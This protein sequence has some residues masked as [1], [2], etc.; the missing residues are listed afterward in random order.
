VANETPVTP[1]PTPVPD[2]IPITDPTASQAI[3][4]DLNPEYDPAKDTRAPFL[5]TNLNPSGPT[6][7]AAPEPSVVQKAKKIV[8]EGIPRYSSRT[9]ENPKYGREQF[10]SPEEALTPAEQKQ[11][12]VLTGAL[13]SAGGLTSPGTIGTVAATAGLGETPALIQKVAEGLFALQMGKGVYD[14]YPELKA[15]IEKGKAATTPEQRADAFADTQRILTHMGVDSF[16]ALEAATHAGKGAGEVASKVGTHL[17]DLAQTAVAS[18]KE[19]GKAALEAKAPEGSLEA[20]FAK[21]GGKKVGSVP[22]QLYHGTP[23]GDLRG[24]EQGLHVGTQRAATQAL[25]ARI[26]IRADGQPWDGTQEYGKTLL[27]GKKTLAKL[28]PTGNNVTGYNVDVPEEDHYPTIG[29]AVYSDKTPVATDAKPNVMPVKITGPMRNT[30][31]RPLTDVGANRIGAKIKGQSEAAGAYYKN[32]GEDEGSISAVLPGPGHVDPEA[33]ASVGGKFVGKTP[34]PP[35]PAVAYH[36]DLQKI[37]DK[38]GT[39]TDPTKIADG[40]SFIAPDGKFIPLGST[41]HDMA[42]DW[43]QGS[44]GPTR[45]APDNRVAFINDSK[46]VR[47][48]PTTDKGGTTLHISVPREGISPEQIDALKQ[49]VAKGLG[50]GNVMMETADNPRDIKTAPYKELATDTD[51]EPML[52]QIGAHPDQQD[53]LSKELQS[54]LKEKYTVE[55]T[56]ADGTTHMEPIEAFSSKNAIAVA[57]KKFPGTRAYSWRIE[58]MGEREPS[59][60]YSVPTGKLA[61]MPASAGRPEIH[62]IRHELGHAMVGQNEGLVTGG[63]L[64]SSHPDLGKDA[65]AAVRWPGRENILF[66]PAGQVRPDK[67]APIVKTLMGGIAADEVFN[68]LPRS[69][70]H[71][72]FLGTGGDGSRAYQILQAAG[73]SHEDAMEYMHKAIDAGKEY[74]QH[75]AVSGIINENAGFRE[76]GLSRQFHAS[77]DR[78]TSMHQ[79]AQRRIANATGQ[80]QPDNRAVSG[81]GLTGR[82]GNVARGEGGSAQATG[83]SPAEAKKGI[84]SKEKIKTPE[85]DQLSAHEEGGG[86]TFTPAGE[87]LAGKDLYSVGAYPERTVQVDKLTPEVLAK[88]KADN[89]DV[90][91]KGDH[92]VG[93]WKDPD[94]GKAVLDVS[95]T[96]ADRAEAVAAGKDA[97]QK[98]IYHLGGEGEIQTGGTGEG[99]APKLSAKE[100]KAADKAT[101]A[102]AQQAAVFKPSTGGTPEAPAAGAAPAAS[103]DIPTVSTR[104]PTKK[105]KGEVVEDHTQRDMTSD[106]DAAKAAP[107]Y[108]QKMVNRTNTTPGFTPPEGDALA[109]A[110]AYIRHAADNIKFV[111]SKMLP[112]AIKRDEKWYP[113]GAH[114][115]VQ[116]VAAQH[117]FTPHQIAGV[118]AVESPMTDWDQNTSLAERTANIWKNQQATKFT[119]EM[120]DAADNI[121]SLPANSSFKPLIK[122]VQGKTLAE[123][124][125][126]EQQAIW[127][128]LYDE[129]HNPRE[130]QTWN[131]DGTSNGLALNQDGSPR[132]VGWSFQS[133]IQK[134]IEILK[135]GSPENISKNLGYGHKVRNFY[136]NMLSP[137]D[138]RY[139]TMD[140]HA[141]NVAQLRPMSGKIPAVRDNFGNIK[142]GEYGLKGT[143][144]LHDAAYRLAAKELDI[145]IPSRLQSPTWTKIRDVFTDDFKTPE[146][147]QAIDAIW[148]EHSDG[149]ITAD[150]ARNRIWDY[151]TEWNRENAAGTGAP[152]DQGKLFAA[153][154]SGEPASGTGR[155]TGVGTPREVPE[156]ELGSTDFN[157]GANV[158]DVHAEN[159]AKVAEMMKAKQEAMQK[160]LG[161]G[162]KKK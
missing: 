36:P 72:F 116:A 83:T 21:L 109:H 13:E 66:N 9:V 35:A 95:K 86:S 114:E 58:K 47:V 138:P 141:I 160:G 145:P 102:A 76:A 148:K 144:A 125:T 70:N 158:K 40:P 61:K 122:K 48:R 60:E 113:V 120:Q 96:Y 51:I 127:L 154:V 136:N 147:Q 46:A 115:R 152:A 107:G 29:K 110:N 6:I 143:Y 55:I 57:Q 77:P 82:E 85:D 112:D 12:P 11:A 50:Y 25:E 101:A 56:D 43:A 10:L 93:T 133:H 8:T 104:V 31:A 19:E 89:A 53:L 59:T 105:V 124:P 79:E 88:F 150:Q 149:K 155:G 100:Q 106:M 135:D 42:I 68:D 17:K 14:Q 117:G 63:M 108:L 131:P 94:T 139:L 7:E 130:Y 75:P 15:S 28:D 157:F 41:H 18:A 5:K 44:K 37:A 24:G 128:R 129:G 137:D 161:K 119:P 142:N 22:Q 33:F 159:T 162:L 80:E 92:A 30:P 49:G 54:P 32:I 134:A 153:G 2:S 64:S 74:L 111:M 118:T 98:A 34:E 123:L 151:A 97:N 67:V 27:A 26:G 140:T 91:E 39:H 90:L 84:V 126:T 73:V 1:T 87:N 156:E 78:L 23:S 99:P 65:R 71:N 121:T 45:E 3:P 132:N 20:G 52:K 38:F 81:E 4:I 103:K 62:T 146:N 69:A 16:M